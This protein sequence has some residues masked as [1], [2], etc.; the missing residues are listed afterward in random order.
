MKVIKMEHFNV[1]CT[2]ELCVIL[3]T[4]S[5]ILALIWGNQHDD[6]TNKLCTDI[7]W[8]RYD[9]QR[10]SLFSAMSEKILL[11]SYDNVCWK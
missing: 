10:Q 1:S 8:H 2:I 4:Y 9:T 6:N 5:Q 3:S 7:K 11:A